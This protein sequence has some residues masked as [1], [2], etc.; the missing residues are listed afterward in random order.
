[1]GG[2]YLT[3]SLTLKALS[4]V[5]GTGYQGIGLGLVEMISSWSRTW[6]AFSVAASIRSEHEIMGKAQVQR[7]RAVR[8]IE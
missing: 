4:T 2:V 7:E 5:P 6:I 8:E 1:M 3:K